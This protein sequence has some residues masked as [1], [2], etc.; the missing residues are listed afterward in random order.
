MRV[1]LA[2]LISLF[3]FLFEMSYGQDAPGGISIPPLPAYCSGKNFRS[4][5]VGSATGSGPARKV[6]YRYLSLNGSVRGT[7]PTFVLLPGGPG[8]PGTW[9]FKDA[10]EVADG[11]SVPRGYPMLLFDSRGV[12]CNATPELSQKST[13]LTEVF[14]R[15][16]AEAIKQEKLENYVL[17]G[18]SYGTV[19]ATKLYAE[20]KHQGLK[21][22]RTVVLMGTIGRSWRSP[23]ER[24]ADFDRLLQ[25]RLNELSNDAREMILGGVFPFAAS[26]RQIAQLFSDPLTYAST[27]DS[28]GVVHDSFKTRFEGIASRNPKTLERVNQ[29]ISETSARVDYWPK[30]LSEWVADQVDCREL[31][32]AVDSDFVRGHLVVAS[33]REICSM[34]AER[35]DRSFDSK[36]YVIG[37]NI[38]YLEGALDGATPEWQSRYHLNHQLFA[39]NRIYISTPTGGHGGTA[40]HLA[41]C[42]VP[43]WEAILKGG[44]SGQFVGPVSAA[45]RNCGLRPVAEFYDSRNLRRFNYR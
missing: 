33:P 38:V 30:N 15:D 34:V 12:G 28:S 7:L 41:D 6:P 25:R 27:V 37:A 14:A 45:I 44:E 35:A 4:A 10:D 26:P 20:M 42:S 13:L 21:L 8:L 1:H 32:A 3:S 16:V 19:W 24:I 39:K 5:S 31:E 18:A 29:I 17:V 23:Y 2:L 11:W 36:D 43:L 9:D 22:P 40:T